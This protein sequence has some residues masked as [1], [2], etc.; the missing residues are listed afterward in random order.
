M[1]DDFQPL[2]Q[3]EWDWFAAFLRS[4]V[5][6]LEGLR[7]ARGSVAAFQRRF[8][9]P[10]WDAHTARLGYRSTPFP[11][12]GRPGRA[13][14]AG[15]PGAV[16]IAVAPTA[17][18]PALAYSLESFFRAL[19][20]DVV[21]VVE[22]V[23][24]LR[25]RAGHGDLEELE[26][27]QLIAGYLDALRDRVDYVIVPMAGGPEPAPGAGDDAWR[28]YEGRSPRVIWFRHRHGTSELRACLAAI[29][30]LLTGDRHRVEQ[31]CDRHVGHL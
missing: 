12:D 17:D 28:L 19:G 16:S 8:S 4:S 24:R 13:R 5:D 9:G 15:A 29:G 27:G 20:A 22:Q 26:A 1:P 23:R 7:E 3:E 21:P 18:S 6:D 30:A 11:S 14:A 10:A 25:Q 2:V 31:S